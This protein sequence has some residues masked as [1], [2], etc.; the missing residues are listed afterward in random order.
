MS[1]VSLTCPPIPF[2]TGV[3]ALLNAY[4]ILRYLQFHLTEKQFQTVFSAA[5]ISAVVVFVVMVGLTYLGYIAH[6]RGHMVAAGLYVCVSVSE[7][8]SG[9]VYT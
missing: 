4:A 3:F 9:I 6:W 8:V 5:I 2:P 1:T 7:C